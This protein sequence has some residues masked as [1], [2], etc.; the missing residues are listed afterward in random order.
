MIKEVD[1]KLVNEIEK[2]VNKRKSFTQIGVKLNLDRKLV[3]DIHANG[4]LK[5]G[6]KFFKI[7]PKSLKLKKVLK[8]YFLLKKNNKLVNMIYFKEKFGINPNFL[9]EWIF[10]IYG[11]EFKADINRKGIFKDNV[12]K[13]IDSPEKAYWLGFVLADGYVRLNSG[14]SLQRTPSKIF[15]LKLG[16]VDKLHVYKFADFIDLK[17]DRVKIEIHAKTGNELYKI[18]LTSPTM[19]D[20]LGKLGITPNKSLKED[21]Y[22]DIDEKF[23]SH[24][25]RGIFEGDGYIRSNLKAIGLCGS[26]N[27]TSK[28]SELLNAILGVKIPLVTSDECKSGERLY[29]I[30][31]YSTEDKTKIL[32]F[33][34]SDINTEIVLDRKYDLAKKLCPLI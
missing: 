29:R 17:H 24:Y 30:A 23:I 25:L 1:I 16:A 8:E 6:E 26:L 27:V 32:K 7:S 31:W 28:F 3:A 4:L 5:I 2:L 11:E 21:I 22:E 14:G 12:F 15:G 18:W 19:F 9:K 34:Y 10:K 33:L 13:N 20:D